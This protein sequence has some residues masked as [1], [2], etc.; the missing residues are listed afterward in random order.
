VAQVA[1]P[2]SFS[3]FSLFPISKSSLISNLN[4][5]FVVL[6]LQIIPVKLGVLILE[7]FNY[8]YYFYIFSLFVS[9]LKFPLGFKF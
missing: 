9:I 2:L 1:P 5:N 4:S 8:I 6:Y 3:Y 7:K